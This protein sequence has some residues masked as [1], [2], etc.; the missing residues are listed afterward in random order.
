M[1]FDESKPMKFVTAEDIGICFDKLKHHITKD[2]LMPS[3]ELTMRSRPV[4]SGKPPIS[5]APDQSEDPASALTYW[6]DL[7]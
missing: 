6:E 1:H 3:P 2:R 5:D 4:T 7:V